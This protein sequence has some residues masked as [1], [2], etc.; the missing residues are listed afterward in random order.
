MSNGEDGDR[1]PGTTPQ[2]RDLGLLLR[3][4][5]QDSNALAALYDLHGALL[6]GVAVR[7][8]R[9]SAD[10]EDVVQ[11]TWMQVWRS[12][13]SYDS[14]RGTVAAWLLT[15]VRSR[16]LDRWRAAAARQRAVHAAETGAPPPAAPADPE[17]TSAHAQLA[18]QLARAL[19]SL[20]SEH[21]RVLELAYF[22]GLSQSEIAERLNA[23]LGTV[24]SWT[25]QGL[26][27]LRQM[28][29]REQGI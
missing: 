28:V 26:L 13:S 24:K 20:P 2:E 4:Q 8:L 5:A 18:S 12:A 29:P 21:R 7:I 14:R 25:R 1:L 11:E 19:A 10:A 9:D 15:L 23:P 3:L 16:A 27:K 17:T 22:G 6:Y